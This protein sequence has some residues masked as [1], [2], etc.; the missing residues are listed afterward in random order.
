MAGRAVGEDP[1]VPSSALVAAGTLHTLDADT[2]AGGLV[3]LRR[4]D[5]PGVA[6]TGS[7]LHAGVSPEEL[8]ALAAGAASEARHAL[9]LPCELITRRPKGMSSIAVAWLTPCPAGQLPGVGRTAVTVLA[10]HVRETQALPGG[11]V[12]LAVRAVT[13][14]LHGAQVIADTL[15]TVLLESVAI[16]TKSAE[17]AVHPSVWYRHL[18]HL[19]VSLSQASG[20]VVSM[21]W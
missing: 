6:V 8:L 17:L 20:S 15:S 9:A 10:D 7:A 3:T 21:L 14:L 19:P 4:L 5:A 2:L 12:T 1:R 11:F 13:M 18:R 16:V